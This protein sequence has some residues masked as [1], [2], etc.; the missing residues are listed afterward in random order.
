MSSACLVACSAGS[1]GETALSTNAPTPVAR[2]KDGSYPEWPLRVAFGEPP[3]PSAGKR[4]AAS[5]PKA[6]PNPNPK[7]LSPQARQAASQKA[8]QAY[9][10]AV[11]PKPQ[12]K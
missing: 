12:K 11:V 3:A 10:R 6:K 2:A 5:P 7:A 4:A 1:D 8:R 9:S